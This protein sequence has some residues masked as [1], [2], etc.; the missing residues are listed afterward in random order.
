MKESWLY[1]YD[2]VTE[3]TGLWMQTLFA[4]VYISPCVFH[5]FPL[6]KLKSHVSSCVVWNFAKVLCCLQ[7]GAQTGK[8]HPAYHQPRTDWQ[9]HLPS[10]VPPATMESESGKLNPT[11][12]LPSTD[13]NDNPHHL[14]YPQREWRQSVPAIE[15]SQR[16]LFQDHCADNLQAAWCWWGKL[17][18]QYKGLLHF[19]FTVQQSRIFF[20]N[21]KVTLRFHQSY[22]VC[23][24]LPFSL[25]PRLYTGVTDILKHILSLYHLLKWDPPHTF[26]LSPDSGGGTWSC[27]HC[28]AHVI[29]LSSTQVGSTLHIFFCCLHNCSDLQELQMSSNTCYPSFIYSDPPCA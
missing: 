28:G 14:R 18:S 25:Y 1:E 9:K 22:S 16:H 2:W 26:F 4:L 8:F 27:G 11:D 7:K 21:K 17:Q 20:I 10:L 19:S 12:H 15:I 24:P 29:P 5:S 13:D 3:E 6:V 23:I